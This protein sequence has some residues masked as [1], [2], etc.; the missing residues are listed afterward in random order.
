MKTN[1][2]TRLCVVIVLCLFS[3]SFGKDSNPN[4][5][6][7]IY[8]KPVIG[9]T[10]MINKLLKT[11][12]GAL[13]ELAVV[14]NSKGDIARIEL[15]FARDR[16]AL[17]A[18]IGSCP[19]TPGHIDSQCALSCLGD[20]MGKDLRDPNIVSKIPFFMYFPILGLK[21]KLENCIKTNTAEQCVNDNINEI[22][23]LV[24]DILKY[25]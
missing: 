17:I 25:I 2:I 6:I 13:Y 18:C 1:V 20:Y 4:N 16:A 9:N 24:D 7:T 8:E 21:S 19:Q 22:D 12:N 10:S 5:R 15:I 14:S 3:L 11:K 23:H